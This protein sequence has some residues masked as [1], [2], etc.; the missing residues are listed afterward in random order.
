M[1]K[2]SALIRKLVD[3]TAH[4][5]EIGGD[6]VDLLKER[7]FSDT[8]IVRQTLMNA[9]CDSRFKLY[10]DVV[11]Y[12]KAEA[13][14]ALEQLAK[15][16]QEQKNLTAGDAEPLLENFLNAWLKMTFAGAELDV[17][18][19]Q[20]YFSPPKGK[21]D[22]SEAL[23]LLNELTAIDS[24]DAASMTMPSDGDKPALA[25]KESSGD[26]EAQEPGA[27][28][29]QQPDE[30]DDRQPGESDSESDWQDNT[31]RHVGSGLLNGSSYQ[32]LEDRYL[33]R[34]PQSLVELARKIGRI[35]QGGERAGR[36]MRAG[37][38]DIAGI[39]VGNDI[40]AILPSELAL[41]AQPQT[42]DVFYQKYAARRLQ[43]FGSASQ[44]DSRN[45]HQDG[46]VIICVD[47]SG[48][49]TG[50]PMMVAKTL[51]AAVAIIAWRRKRDVIVVKYSDSYSYRDL[52]H[53]RSM[54]GEMSN[55]LAEVYMGGND[56]NGMFRWF[57]KDVMPNMNGYDTAD[58]LCISDFGWSS[59]DDD[60]LSIINEQK[61]SGMKF[62]G[63]NVPS[64]D[65]SYLTSEF[66]DER[67]PMNVCD[68][69]WEYDNGECK[70]VS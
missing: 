64:I 20:D 28:T 23:D 65:D 15:Q 70:Q 41:L 37:K 8:D 14:N 35:G 44:T 63:L 43:L 2:Y 55:F 67:Q 66:G 9:V 61:R 34:I 47:T 50:V 11:G 62:Y 17:D 5:E 1:K 48:S 56:E 40:S 19:E 13:R 21:N 6:V 3:A 12:W 45:K 32:R 24:D 33:Q 27:Q 16:L 38:S 69:V 36:F 46:P 59:L 68:S 7:C 22:L 29:V 60:T 31:N 52:G 25:N 4:A 18:P 51:A 30:Q 58:I 54:L 42:Q 39:T 10:A 57:F 26:A 53:N 49:M